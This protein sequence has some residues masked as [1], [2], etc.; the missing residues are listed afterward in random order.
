MGFDLWSGNPNYVSLPLPGTGKRKGHEYTKP[1][2]QLSSR[3]F[4]GLPKKW[5]LVCVILAS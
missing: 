2:Q 5:A 3:P 4:T 1:F